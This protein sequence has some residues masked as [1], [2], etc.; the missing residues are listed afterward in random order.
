[1][2]VEKILRIF[3]LLRRDEMLGAVH[4]PK[5]VENSRNMFPVQSIA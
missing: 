3:P 5:L 2:L 1:M 4:L